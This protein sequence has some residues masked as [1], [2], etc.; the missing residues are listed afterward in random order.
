MAALRREIGLAGLT[1]IGIGG[2]IGSGW[3][4]AP[5]LAAQ[6]AGPAAILAWC[7]GAFAMLLVALAFAEVVASLPEAGAIARVPH[8]SHGAVVSMLIGWSAWIGYATL[9]PIETVILLKYVGPL[10]PGFHVDGPAGALT[11]VGAGLSIAILAVMALINA[12]GV[13]WFNRANAVVTTTKILIPIVIAL[14]IIGTDF[15]PSNFSVHGGFA[16]NGLSGI[17]SAVSAGGV[18]YAYIGFRHIIDLAGEARRPRATVP[19]ALTLSVVICF[20]VY[21]LLQTA[22]IGG[23]PA[24][25]LAKGW[26]GIAFEHHLG[27]L[28]AIAVVTGLS[29]LIAL[30]YGGALLAP[31]GAAL[32][33]T[34]SN[35][36]LSMALSRNGFFPAMLRSL[37]ARNV[38]LNALL[39]GFAAS[40][41]IL[42]TIPFE[43]MVAL[44][45]AAVVV[46]LCMGPLALVTL[47]R[48]LPERSRPIRLPWAPLIAPLGFVISVLIIYW[49]GWNTIWRLG[50]AMLL[51]FALFGLK[52]WI[53]PVKGPRDWPAARWLLALFG[54]LAVISCLGNFGNGLRLIPFG[55]DLAAVS[56]WALFC[57]RLGLK[58]ALPPERTRAL[59][60]AAA[61]ER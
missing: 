51:G 37:S 8:Y 34:A 17:L 31:F 44:A 11:P 9:A 38:P 61:K 45:S 35:A 49:T 29:W 48:Q 32:I 10:I 22:F 14:T 16:P 25:A 58:D 54:G 46:S 42:L 26:A 41:L 43:E 20:A 52:L 57:F 3:L 55:W 33:A 1:F 39:L 36:R 18:V 28:A 47:R 15:T 60:E 53:E 19:V 4:F 40:V 23:L 12:L 13:T 2:V 6:Q 50:L 27:P 5:L 24:A 21:V 30:L 56:V 59:V 7:I